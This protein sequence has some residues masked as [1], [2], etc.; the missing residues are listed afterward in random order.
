MRLETMTS[1]AQDTRDRIV[2]LESEFK[3]TMNRVLNELSDAKQSRERL[4]ARLGKVEDKVDT[5][6]T[7]VKNVAKDLEDIKPTVADINKWRE[8]GV[9]AVLLVSFAAASIGGL[10]TAFGKKLWALVSG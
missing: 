2:S 5:T 9:G 6:E 3:A 4:A 8:R 10:V 1:L 7:V